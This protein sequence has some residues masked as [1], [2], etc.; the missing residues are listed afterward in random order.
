MTKSGQC[1]LS[2]V[3]SGGGSW[4]DAFGVILYESGW[5]HEGS[6]R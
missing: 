2:S 1:A 4:Q 3:C 5:L 6:L